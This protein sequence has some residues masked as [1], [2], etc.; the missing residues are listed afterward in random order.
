MNEGEKGSA[1]LLQKINYARDVL[2]KPKPPE[3][4]GAAGGGAKEAN[5]TDGAKEKTS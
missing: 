5:A 2:V 3:A 1:Y 4:D